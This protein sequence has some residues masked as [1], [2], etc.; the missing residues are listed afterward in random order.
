[1]NETAEPTPPRYVTEFME[2]LKKRGPRP[3]AVIATPP[4]PEPVPDTIDTFTV[5][6]RDTQQQL[7][8]WGDAKRG[9]AND[10]VRS[11]LFSV[12]RGVNR[13]HLTN[14]RIASLGNIALRYSGDLLTQRDEDVYLHLIHLQRMH[15]VGERVAFVPWHAIREL[16]WS[17]SQRSYTELLEA[18][19]RLQLS[20]VEIHAKDEHMERRFGGSLVRNYGTMRVIGRKEEVWFV[21]FEPPILKL[22]TPV[23]YTTIDWDQRLRLSP[24][25]KWL[26]SFYS[27]HRF[28]IPLRVDFI[29]NLCGSDTKHLPRFR[30]MLRGALKELLDSGFLTATEISGKDQ[31]L[32]TRAVA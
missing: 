3:A 5:T 18:I 16:G 14:A 20:R 13:P 11:A 23:S 8:Y 29:R 31:I 17:K 6:T 22:F 19:R 1:M 9:V 32:V 28:P 15:P 7:P 10:L 12:S 2:T 26:H 30:Q 27:T 24:L 4:P 25:A 21:T